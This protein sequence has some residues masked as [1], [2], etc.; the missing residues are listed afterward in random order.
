[1][2][3]STFFTFSL[4]YYNFEYIDYHIIFKQVSLV[5]RA[6]LFYSFDAGYNVNMSPLNKNHSKTFHEPLQQ[7]SF[8][9]TEGCPLLY[10]LSFIIVTL[11]RMQT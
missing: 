5:R 10:V 8:N 3:T 6:R 4:S 11:P 2:Y 9:N 1:M 7:F